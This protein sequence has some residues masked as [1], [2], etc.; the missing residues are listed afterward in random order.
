MRDASR[1][2]VIPGVIVFL[3]TLLHP[4][5]CPCIISTDSVGRDKTLDEQRRLRPMAAAR[6]IGSDWVVI[7]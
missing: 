6:V 3:D 5:Y 2:L 4:C 1:A 7:V